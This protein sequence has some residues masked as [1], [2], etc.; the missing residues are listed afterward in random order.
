MIKLV[1]SDVDGT[2][3]PLGSKGASKRTMESIERVQRAGVRFGLSTGRD[4]QELMRLFWD[5]DIAFRTG[6][7]S[8][9]K[10]LKVDGSIV[11]LTLIQNEGLERIARMVGEYERTFVTAY[12]LHTDSS[13]PVYCMGIAEQD[14]AAWSRRFSFTG[15]LCDHVPDVEVLGATIACPLGDDAM[16]EIVARGKEI[17]PQF[18]FVMPAPDWCDIVPKG[19]NKGTALPLLLKELNME[20]DEVVVFGDSG[21]DL[22]I[23]QAVKNSVAVDN[24]TPQIKAATAWHI[25]ACEDDAVAQALDDIAEVAGTDAAPA[26]MRV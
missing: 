2:L 26:F 21:N 1:L 4:E 3:I 12:P 24:A 13:N 19:L 25:G 14:V 8:N 20:E 18:D 17:C 15:V 9:G 5:N 22:S 10:K 6:I 7:L 11:R 23:L 16:A